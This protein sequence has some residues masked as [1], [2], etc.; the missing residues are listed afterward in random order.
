MVPGSKSRSPSTLSNADDNSVEQ[1]SSKRRKTAIAN[2][3]PLDSLEDVPT[4]DAERR[5]TKASKQREGYWS[6]KEV[7]ERLHQLEDE[8]RDESLSSSRRKRLRARLSE[9]AK[10]LRG[11]TK[12]GGQLVKKE[13]STKIVEKLKEKNQRRKEARRVAEE[14]KEN[15]LK[16]KKSHKNKTCLKC[17]YTSHPN[18][19]TDTRVTKQCYTPPRH[20]AS[21]HQTTMP[22]RKISELLCVRTL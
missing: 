22:R 18:T 13:K 1:P 17:T 10:A 9:L 3:I 2:S 6:I 5:S 21:G 16:A 14:A 15:E 4:K 8:L 11:K 20:Y 19:Y 12:V 7:T